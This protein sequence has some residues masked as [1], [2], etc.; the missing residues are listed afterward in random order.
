M[1]DTDNFLSKV[2]SRDE[3]HRMIDES[4]EFPGGYAVLLTINAS[5]D[6]EDTGGYGVSSYT[7]PDGLNAIERA[8][9]WAIVRTRA[10]AEFNVRPCR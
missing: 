5:L 9:V 2:V 1:S 8:G 6:P 7:T 3:M 10:E 4:L